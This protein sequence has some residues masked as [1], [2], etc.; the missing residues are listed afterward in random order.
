[1]SNLQEVKSV[2]TRGLQPDATDM[3]MFVRSSDEDLQGWDRQRIVDAL[4]KETMIDNDTAQ[5]IGREVEGFVK[6]SNIKFV[7][8]APDSRIGQRQTCGIR[9]GECPAH[10][11][12]AGYALSTMWSS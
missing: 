8:R 1:M 11:Y 2:S 4:L 3:A 7:S 9:V 12:P 10:A 6:K 5:Q